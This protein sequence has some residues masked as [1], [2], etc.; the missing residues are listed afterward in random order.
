[1]TDKKVKKAL[2]IFEKLSDDE[3]EIAL[4]AVEDKLLGKTKWKHK[5]QGDNYNEK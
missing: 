3:K 4:R 1:M 5:V 2:D